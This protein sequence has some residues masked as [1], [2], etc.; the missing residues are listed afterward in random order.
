ML[1]A[2]SLEHSRISKAMPLSCRWGDTTAA[3]PPIAG[4]LERRRAIFE[5]QPH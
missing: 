4:M 3:N 1:L 2:Q 5:A